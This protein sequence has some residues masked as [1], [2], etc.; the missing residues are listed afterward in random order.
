MRRERLKF[1][2]EEI[3]HADSVNIINY[4]MSLG[5]HIKQVSSH[6]FKIEGYGGLYIHSEGH[7]WNWFSQNKGGGSIQFVMNTENKSWVDAVKTLIVKTDKVRSYK[8]QEVI[9]EVTKGELIL[10]E[11]NITFKHISNYLI[12]L[13]GIAKK[14]VFQFIENHKLYENKYGSC[15]FVGYDK[16][17]VC[18]YASIRSTNITGKSFR[19]DVKNSDKSYPFCLEGKNDTLCVF[20]APIDLMSYLTLIK[21]HQIKNFANHCISLGGVYDKALEHYLK[22]N[23]NIKDIV[24]CLD[25]DEAGHLACQQIRGK[26]GGNYKIQRHIPKG[27]DFNDEILNIKRQ[28]AEQKLYGEKEM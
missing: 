11:E 7:K 2:D 18:K 25:N 24:L 4:A 26:Y 19:Y 6:S 8:P 5:Y 27:K 13:R 14:I 16:E 15:I 12:N 10:P 1:T 23:P 3:A 21:I 28:C 20:E 17:K 9:E 22:E